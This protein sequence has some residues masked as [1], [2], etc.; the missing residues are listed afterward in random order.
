[1]HTVV[2]S[3]PTA[4]LT[5]VLDFMGIPPVASEMHAE[6]VES[7]RNKP[8]QQGQQGDALSCAMRDRMA[9][10]YAT[11]NDVLY[12]LEPEFDHFPPP[13]QLVPCL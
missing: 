11:W 13:E 12:A 8:W 5:R 2:T 6:L 3:D 10:I 7:N 1:M 9:A 4:Y